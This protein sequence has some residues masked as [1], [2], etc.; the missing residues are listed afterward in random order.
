[1]LPLACTNL[2]DAVKKLKKS[3]SVPS[4]S[5]W[6]FFF[7]FSGNCLLL[8]VFNE[9]LKIEPSPAASHVL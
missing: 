4:V 7:D 3:F 2:H 5:L 6:W 1:M 8:T 9:F